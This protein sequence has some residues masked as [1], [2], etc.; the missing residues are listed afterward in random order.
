MLILLFCYSVSFHSIPVQSSPYS[1]PV[2][3]DTHCGGQHYPYKYKYKESVCH[4]CKKK[5]HLVKRCH[6]HDKSETR[7]FPYSKSTHH[8]GTES[9]DTDKEAKDG[10]YTMFTVPTS[11]QDV[12]QIMVDIDN[13]PLSMKLDTG[14]HFRSLVR[15]YTKTHRQSQNRN[16]LQLTSQCMQVNQL[17]CW[18]P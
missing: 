18:V 16:L 4:N 8:I 3:R 7:K 6:Q 17:K 14:H 12:I 9:T 11:K 1:I 2:I 5:G 15:L 10:V 13:Y